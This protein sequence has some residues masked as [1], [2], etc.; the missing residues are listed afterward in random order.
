M[1]HDTFFYTYKLFLFLSITCEPNRSGRRDPSN[2]IGFK[3]KRE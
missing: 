3:T 1:R 2:W